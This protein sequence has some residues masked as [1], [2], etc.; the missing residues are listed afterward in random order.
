[1][2]GGRRE[3]AAAERRTGA[4][5]GDAVVT[6][7]TVSLLF[8]LLVAGQATPRTAVEA[9]RW[10][11]S[12]LPS[13]VAHDF[14]RL[15]SLPS[16]AVLGAGGAAALAVHPADARTVRSLSG[17]KSAEE[18]LDGGATAGGAP[19]QLGIAAAVYGL[20]LGL[21]NEDAAEVGS[22]L[23][24]TQIVQSA[25]TVGL[26]YAVDRTRPNGG[27][28][29]FP[30]G[31]SASAFTTADIVLQRF[32]WRAGVAAY[33][34]AAY[35]GASRI[36]ERYHYPSDVV[37]GAAVGIASAR[38]FRGSFGRAAVAVRPLTLPGGGAV[39][40]TVRPRS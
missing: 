5:V 23:V 7:S 29:S 21:H 16:I 33:F 26:K 18:A 34:A 19:V 11:V 37:F 36:A 8:V 38:T 4:H 17:A 6:P 1:M 40:V 30:S 32:G 24:E 28:Y 14:G 9:N 12:G 31:H 22:A 39:F 2:D 3:A 27:Q 20:G 35:V 10:S 13:R 25:V 15:A